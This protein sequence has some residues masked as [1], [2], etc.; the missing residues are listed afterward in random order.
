MR[1]L[2]IGRSNS[3]DIKLRSDH[4]SANH[5]E[6]TLLNNGD[7]KLEDKGSTNGTFVMNK[8]IQPGKPVGI[9]RGDAIRFADVELNWADVP[10]PEDNSKYRAVYGIGTNLENEVRVTGNTVSRYHATLKI[11]KKGRAYIQDHSKNGTTVNG[12]KIQTNQDVRIKRN[13]AI[14]CGGVPV[15]LASLIPANNW[16]KVLGTAAGIAALLAVAFGIWKYVLPTDDCG[17]ES[18]LEALTNATACV[19]GEFIIDVTV[20]DDPT[21]ELFKK[22]GI[23]IEWPEKWEYG[24]SENIKGYARGTGVSPLVNGYDIKPIPYTGTAFFISE[25][26]ELGSNR[27]IAMPW[28]YLD[29]ELEEAIRHDFT[30]LFV[31]IRKFLEVALPHNAEID[32]YY[33]R[34][35]KS[36]I[37]I[38]GHH[39]FLGVLPSGY[40]HNPHTLKSDVL[41]CQVIAESGDQKMD[42]AL[43]RLN[44]KQTPDDI[45]KKGYFH[46]ECAR[47][48][49]QSLQLGEELTTIGYPGGFDVANELHEGK[50][51]RPTTSKISVS[52]R[53]DE[54]QFQF[55]GIGK[56]GQSGSPIVDKDRH[57][58]GVLY[59]GFGGT[60]IT[61]GCNIKHLVELFEKNKAR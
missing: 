51:I 22:F 49:E 32:A 36:P 57:L 39:E 58:V 8:Q 15:S 46:I 19:Y 41:T 59:G 52:N 21:P 60:D 47:V 14:V 18:P 50:E 17:E 27:H 37:E 55:Q 11:D 38:S 44:S 42:V 9:K 30:T 33:E 20:K 26:G 54:Y 12:A 4:V 25:Y 1:I 61:Y 45:V 10:L 2:K 31:Q 40:K 7:M 28:N 3:C 56:G 35:L 53:A 5:A 24:I 6:I 13:D 48:D 16:K 23:D 34:L 29:K 43:L